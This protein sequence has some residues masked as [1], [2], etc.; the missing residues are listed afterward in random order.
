MRRRAKLFVPSITL[1]KECDTPLHRQIYGQ[2]ARAIRAGE[3][4][5][6]LRLPSSRVW[7]RLLGVSRNTV[8]A[9]FDDLAAEDL[10]RGARGAGMVV[11]T[12]APEVSWSGL[13][14]VIRESGY[15]ARAVS[16]TDADGNPIYLTY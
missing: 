1:V 6:G 15:P 8:L 16:L 9:A 14:Q 13:K 11:Q 3:I 2:L 12:K 10:L 4:P 5:G 7:A